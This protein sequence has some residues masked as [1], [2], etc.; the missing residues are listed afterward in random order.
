MGTSLQI[1]SQIIKPSTAI[2]QAI[3]VLAATNTIR[4]EE[5]DETIKIEREELEDSQVYK[6]AVNVDKITSISAEEITEKL[7]DPNSN[8]GLNEDNKLTLY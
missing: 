4:L 1:G 5:L 6:L 8:I 3:R 7:I 2:S